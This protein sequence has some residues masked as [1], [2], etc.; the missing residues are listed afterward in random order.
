MDF[1]WGVNHSYIAVASP[2]HLHLPGLHPKLIA[3]FALKSQSKNCFSGF[4][5]IE[6][7]DRN[8]LE[9]IP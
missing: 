2:C 5:A 7:G 4:V 8:T 1:S 6:P 9:S 3:F